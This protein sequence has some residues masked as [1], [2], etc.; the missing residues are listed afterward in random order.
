MLAGCFLIFPEKWDLTFLANCLKYQSLIS[1]EKVK[2]VLKLSSAEFAHRV[3]KDIQRQHLECTYIISSTGCKVQH[4]MVVNQ[5]MV[6]NI[7]SFF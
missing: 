6:D 2:M 7:A 4:D 1:G 5:I 3:A